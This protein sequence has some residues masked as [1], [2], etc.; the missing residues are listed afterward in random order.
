MNVDGSGPPIRLTTQSGRLSW[1][2][3][4][5]WIVFD[6][7]HNDVTRREIYL[8]DGDGSNPGKVTNGIADDKYPVWSPDGRQI[9]FNSDRDGNSEIY[10]MNADGSGQTNLTQN[11]SYDIWPTWQQR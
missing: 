6:S 11:P 1:S 5:K 2:P 7:F 9:A 4:G 3:D 10:V 8:M